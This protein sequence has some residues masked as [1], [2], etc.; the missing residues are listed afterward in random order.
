[1][2]GYR[3]PDLHL[4]APVQLENGDRIVITTDGVRGDL[5][6]VLDH[7]LPVDRT[8]Q[9][10]LAEM[11]RPDDDAL[12]FVGRYRTPTALSPRPAGPER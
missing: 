1:V 8:A 4:S 11:A 10:I 2:L 7:E 6:A 9:T 3:L 5:M 12:V